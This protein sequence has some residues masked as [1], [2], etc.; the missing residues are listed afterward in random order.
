MGAC[1]TSPTPAASAVTEPAFASSSITWRVLQ[2]LDDTGK[3]D[4]RPA[5]PDAKQRIL[6]R[7]THFLK[8]LKDKGYAPTD[9][10]VLYYRSSEAAESSLR[11]YGHGFYSAFESAWATHG[12]VVLSPDD[13]WLAVQL[14]FC[15]Y[16]ESNAEQ[17]RNLFVDHAGTV[18]LNVA[19]ETTGQWE[20]FMQRTMSAIQEK[21]KANVAA[22]FLPAFSSSTELTNALQ[23]LAVMDCM[24][25]YFTYRYSCCC[26]IERI[27]FLGTL[28]DWQL[29]RQY[30][31]GLARFHLPASKYFDSL[32]QWV[33]AVLAIVDH[34]IVAYKGE[35][36]P[37][38]DFWNSV[39][40][41]RHTYGSGGS[42]Y[43]K[44]WITTFLTGGDF[45]R[46]LE[47]ADIPA[48]RFNVPVTVD[49]NGHVYRVRVLG[50]FTGVE[51]VANVY[52]PQTSLVVIKV[53]TGEE[54]EGRI[55][56][57]SPQCYP[58]M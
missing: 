11:E 57:S 20:T 56:P 51:E 5:N 16:M 14:Q 15:K 7:Y 48:H 38:L 30:V 10:D 54:P 42:S 53:G 18:E 1:H 4:K 33:D 41:M 19:M 24:Q 28:T 25:Q 23:R 12:S 9:Q 26:G 6:R 8:S 52:R 39:I 58:A 49:D 47:V 35:A 3:H 22:D 43:V 29:L 13:V 31:A 36:Q 32:Q 55:N 44:G 34:F 17:L 27:G 50:G 37:S 45:R 40:N 46:E 2:K 21:C